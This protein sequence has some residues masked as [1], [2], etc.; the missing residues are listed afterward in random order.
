MFR[1]RLYPIVETLRYNT[2]T[3]TIAGVTVWMWSLRVSTTLEGNQLMSS[4]TD[5]NQSLGIGTWFG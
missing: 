4:V 1:D 3:R 5:V 2:A